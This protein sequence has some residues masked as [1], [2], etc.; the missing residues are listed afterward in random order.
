[1]YGA[2]QG[3]HAEHEDGVDVEPRTS[4]EGDALLGVEAS[5]RRTKRDGHATLSSCISNLS[6]TIIGS[7][8]FTRRA[9]RN[10]RCAKLRLKCQACSR[11]LS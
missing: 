10:S 9:F 6:N 2:A 3:H 11:F 5:A 8:E 1:M 7:G 4:N